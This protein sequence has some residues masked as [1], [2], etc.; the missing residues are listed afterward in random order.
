ML[1]KHS[2][3]TGIVYSTSVWDLTSAKEVAGLIPYLIKIPSACNNN[4]VMLFWLCDNY[5]GE[6]HISTRM[7]IKSELEAVVGLFHKYDRANDLVLYASTS[8]YPVPFEDI[9]FPVIIWVLPLIS[10]HTR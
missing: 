7:T 3:E 5:S 4:E 1:K 10:R 6:I 8:G 9:G 2:K